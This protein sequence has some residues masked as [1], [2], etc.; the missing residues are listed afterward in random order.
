M[1]IFGAGLYQ[2]LVLKKPFG[3]HPTSDG[4]LIATAIFVIL[5]MVGVLWLTLKMKLILEV[6]DEGIIYRFPP[7]IPKMRTITKEMIAEFQVRKYNPI[8]EYGGWGI[9]G[10]F[11]G[12]GKAYNVKGNMGLQLR[13]NDNKRV[14]FGTQRPDALKFA[15]EKMM[16]PS[17]Y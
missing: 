4:A 2:Q 8:G 7:L 16:N 9:K 13:L 15:M 11:M 14:L 10:T 5:I 3:D 12:R 6:T 17:G 1:V